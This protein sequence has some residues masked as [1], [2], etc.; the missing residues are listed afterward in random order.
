M[1]NNEEMWKVEDKNLFLILYFMSQGG[2]EIL[3][4]L[5]AARFP[6]RSNNMVSC[7]VGIRGRMV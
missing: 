4:N 3:R 6:G 1:M 2:R 7:S 5:E